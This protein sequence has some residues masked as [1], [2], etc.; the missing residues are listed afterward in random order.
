M[1]Y[2]ESINIYAKSYY[3]AKGKNTMKEVKKLKVY[4]TCNANYE[5]VPMLRLQGKWLRELGFDAGTAINVECKKEKIIV[6]VASHD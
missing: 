6:S 2:G 4:G 5:K 3:L 1:Y